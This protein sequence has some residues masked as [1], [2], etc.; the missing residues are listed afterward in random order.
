MLA[1]H[2][3]PHEISACRYGLGPHVWFLSALK[4]KEEED[5][6]F[7]PQQS[8]PFLSVGCDSSKKEEIPLF[9]SSLYR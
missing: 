4:G 1:E 6:P 7:L 2:L 3:V 5:A 8:I 9:S